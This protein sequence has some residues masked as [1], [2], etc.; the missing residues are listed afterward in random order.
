M[1][2]SY[3]K[4]AHQ[5]SEP[6]EGNLSLHVTQTCRSA[7]WGGKAMNSRGKE[8]GPR[9]GRHLAAATRK[10]GWDSW[11]QLCCQ[12]YPRLALGYQPPSPRRHKCERN[13]HLFP[14]SHKGWPWAAWCLG[15]VWFS[16]ELIFAFFSFVFL[17][18]KLSPI[19]VS[20]L[21]TKT[22]IVK[23]DANVSAEAGWNEW[24]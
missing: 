12:S 5:A 4:G 17:S 9:Q 13:L 23:H 24:P 14:L 3:P 15:T 11:W 20:E 21:S 16:H 10:P 7:A 18:Q 6:W 1:Y 19:H 2:A 8:R 22:H